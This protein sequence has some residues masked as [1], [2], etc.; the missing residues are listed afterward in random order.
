MNKL[1]WL[2]LT[3]FPLR[4]IASDIDLNNYRYFVTSKPDEFPFIRLSNGSKWCLSKDRIDFY[5]FCGS[6]TVPF[7]QSMEVFFSTAMV[8]RF[9]EV[10]YMKSIDQDCVACYCVNK[11]AF[12]TIVEYS[13]ICVEEPGWFSRGAYKSYVQL[14]DG[15]IW[16]IIGQSNSYPKKGN[17]VL[18]TLDLKAS[19]EKC[20]I[21][22]LVDRV[23]YKKPDLFF[24]NENYG[25]PFVYFQK[26][27]DVMPV[28]VSEGQ[29][30]RTND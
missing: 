29:A 28:L 21:I 16:E 24:N 27:I 2:F 5:K 20:K 1:I 6:P 10:F 8:E 3:I 25:K 13:T 22:D 11:D 15:S 30:I 26:Q 23:R 9:D 14:S 12:P 4:L 19:T 7:E 18:V 17:P